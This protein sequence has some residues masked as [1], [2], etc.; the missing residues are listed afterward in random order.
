MNDFAEAVQ[1]R[2]LV[3]DGAMGTMLHAAGNSLDRA[4][5]ELNLSNPNLVSTIHESYVGA[6]VDLI[7]TNTFGASRLRLAEHGHAGDVVEINRAGVRLAREAAG[8][9]PRSV[10][11][12]GSIAAAVTASKRAQVPAAERAEAI[13]EQVAAL[14]NAGVD[15]LVLETFGYLDELLEAVQIAADT[16]DLPIL[17]QATFTTDARTPGGETPHEV[18]TALSELPTTAIGANCTVGPQ[19]MLGI[20][21]ELRRATDLPISVQPNAGLPRRVDGRRF[22]YNLDHDYFVRYALRCADAG[23]SVIGGCCG[24]TPGHMRAVAVALSQRQKRPVLPSKARLAA[25]DEFARG[26]AR[27]GFVVAAEIAPPAGG[28]ADEA[29]EIATELRSFGTELI[30]VSAVGSSRA[31]LAPS[32]LALHLQQQVGV[33]TIT[34]ATTWDKTIMSLQADLLGAH[35]FGTQNVLCDTGNPPLRGDYPNADGIWEVDSVG[36]IE[37]LSGLNAGR[38][39]NGLS[40]ATKTSFHIG[41]RCNPGAADI[42]TEI[43][44]TRAKIAAGAQFL[45]TRPVYE[46]GGLR[47]MLD[48]LG[49]DGVPVLVTVSPLNGFAEAEYLAYE[50]PDVTIPPRTLVELEAASGR[51]RETAATLATDLVTQ[52]RALADGVVI[53][54]G[55]DRRTAQQLL[56][57]ARSELQ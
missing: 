16:T 11:V 35:A 29:A 57:T 54:V 36:L 43:A 23:A 27:R 40:L 12:G 19:R 50:V 14:A 24:T 31:Q 17:A 2:L 3:G 7:L 51:E 15:L 52:A 53:V 6:G 38:D 22:E 46:M 39:C 45:I 49:L 8:A 48:A 20:V 32:S 1:K 56:T 41:A 25:P 21:E 44:R 34:T 33:E 9:V 10:F 4:L 42:D 30:L 18:A 5:P 28:T 37:L 47:R 13:R 55:R 26:L